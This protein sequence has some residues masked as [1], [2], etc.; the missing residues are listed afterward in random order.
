MVRLRLQ[1]W[2][3]DLFIASIKSV[4]KDEDRMEVLFWLSRSQ[5]ILGNDQPIKDKFVGLYA[6]MDGQK[7]VRIVV[8]AVTESVKNYASA[9]LPLAV[10]LSVPLTL[11]A[12]PFVGGQGAGIAALGGAVGLP[13]LLLIFLGTAGITA[14]L[15]PFAASKDARNHLGFILG[16]IARD[17]VL[18][19]IRAAIKNGSQGAPSKPVPTEMPED[20]R[21][22]QASLLA[23]D[24]YRF[25]NHVMS[26]FEAA[27]LQAWVTKKSS[28]MG[29]DG[30]ARHPKG[31]IVV[32]CKRNG[33]DNLVGGPTVQQFKG[34]IEENEAYIGYLVTTSG[35]T[36]RA[37]FSAEHSAKLVLVAMN[38][39]VAWHKVAPTFASP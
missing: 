24:P 38:E 29:V 13:V 32:Q 11:L 10:K 27:G 34:V 6:L 12:V 31:L 2:L 18:R 9:D 22:I 4:S 20:E 37:R 15:E 28:D 3:V 7:T 19:H 8:N 14:I 23:M 25:E 17:E 39:L 16:L 21:E 33:P 5:D 1:S 36:D 26:F 30:F 35:F